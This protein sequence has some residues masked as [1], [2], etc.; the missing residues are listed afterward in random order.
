M[1]TDDERPA[2]APGS[3][4]EKL[5]QEMMENAPTRDALRELV[6]AVNDARRG[7]DCHCRMCVRVDLALANIKTLLDA[8]NPSHALRAEWRDCCDCAHDK[9]TSSE[10]CRDCYEDPARPSWVAKW[11]EGTPA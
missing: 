9:E 3:P 4:G 5:F 11:A 6:M 1:S 2:F 10:R 7:I 8:R